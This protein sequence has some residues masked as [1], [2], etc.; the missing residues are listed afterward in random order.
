M[1]RQG[2]GTSDNA[3]D[4]GHNIIHGAGQETAE[5]RVKASHQVRTGDRAAKAV[6]TKDRCDDVYNSSSSVNESAEY[7]SVHDI[8]PV[9]VL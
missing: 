4:T 9:S 1:P 8:S 7:F 3:I 5:D 2:D 6:Q